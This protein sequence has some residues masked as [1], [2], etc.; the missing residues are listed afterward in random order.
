[1]LSRRVSGLE[2]TEERGSYV[3]SVDL[4]VGYVGWEG[5]IRERAI[6]QR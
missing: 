5:V 2:G 6:R 4:R 1:M 3:W